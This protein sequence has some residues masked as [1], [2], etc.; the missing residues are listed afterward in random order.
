[1]TKTIDLK[2][3]KL[4]L[5]AQGIGYINGKVCFVDFVIPGEEVKADIIVEKKDYNVARVVEIIKSSPARV[6]PLCSVFGLCGG[7]QMQ[8][9]DYNKQIELK[10]EILIDTLRHIGKIEYSDIKVFYNQPW[11]Y[12]NRAQLPVQKNKELKI[13]YFKKGTHEVVSHNICCI[14]QKE[15]NSVVEILRGRIK[16]SNIEIYNESRHKGN[17]RHI[18]V[19]RGTNTGQIFITFVTKEKTLPGILYTGLLNECK[20]I[21]GVSQNINTKRTNRIFGEKNIIISGNSFYEEIL[22]GKR[23]QVG[24]TSFFQVNTRVFEQIIKKIKQEIQGPIVI[25]LYAGVGVIGICVAELCNKLIAIEENPNSVKE[26]I[27]NANLN[28]VDNIDFI[29]GRVEDKICSVREC[30][31]LIMDPPRKGVGESVI[32]YFKDMNVKKVVYLSCNPATLARDANL[33]IKNGYKIKN[34]Y[35]FDMFPQTYHIESLTIFYNS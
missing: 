9:I 16:K 34:V 17:L 10:R 18:I 1:M 11:Y 21:V 31:T 3:E 6:E 28:G 20:E 15:I 25:D 2:I 32:Q 12:R 19:K 22:D 4:N 30:D 23:F 24:P 33:I 7:C 26:G 29:E 14:N 8:H 13:G 5:G 35:L 27:N